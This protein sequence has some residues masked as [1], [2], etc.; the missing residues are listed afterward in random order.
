MP[1]GIP[2]R[3]EIEQEDVP[4]IE[5]ALRDYAKTCIDIA[6]LG[7]LLAIVGFL[8]EIRSNFEEAQERASLLRIAREPAAEPK[9]RS[10]R[11]GARGAG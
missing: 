10:T 7:S 5:R 2:I 3:V 11:S 6:S 1:D 4:A 9:V 8:D